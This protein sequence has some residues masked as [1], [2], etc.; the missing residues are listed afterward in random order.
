MRK[1][2]IFL[3]YTTIIEFLHLLTVIYWVSRKKI[4][5]YGT[6]DDAL[7]SSISSG[8]LTGFPDPHLIFIQ[9]LISYPIIWLESLLTNFSGYTIFLLFGTTIS[10]TLVLVNRIINKNYNL[11]FYLSW[12]FANIIFHSWFAINPTYTG[13]SLFTSGAAAAL[14]IILLKN[15]FNGNYPLVFSIA[16]LFTL[17]YMIRI[18]GVYIYFLI[19]IPF[20]FLYLK[21]LILIKRKIGIII[22]L[23]S[24]PLISNMGLS[25]KLYEN[26][27]WK[28]YTEMNNLRHKIQL[29]EPE[30]QMDQFLSEINWDEP[31][32]YMFKR[33]VL[34]DPDFMNSASMEKIIAQTNDYVGI[35]SVLKAEPNVSIKN[36]IDSLKPW[37]WILQ[38][39]IFIIFLNL[40]IRI[41]NLSL[42]TKYIFEVSILTSSIFVLLYTLASGF[43]LPEAITLN[44]LAA[45]SLV[46]VCL[47]P[48]KFYVNKK[49]FINLIVLLVSG[50][51]VFKQFERFVI[52]LNAR[53]DYYKTRQAFALQQKQS[54]NQLDSEVVVSSAASLKFHWIYPYNKYESFDDRN[55]T[56]ILGWHNLSPAWN[57]AASNLGLDPK[58]IYSSLVDNE[59]VWVDSENNI[60]PVL[61]FLEINQNANLQFNVLG[62]VGNQEY[63]FYK[64][65]SID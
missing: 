49:T 42:V 41:N 8:K 47:S 18:E 2:V 28:E 48:D 44:L 36:A 65:K 56:L 9:P 20:I 16:F 35:K 5:I 31:T 22:I 40:Y 27:A 62:D 12:L 1:L 64:F 3:F 26:D 46:L 7:I 53:E 17:S 13:A 61:K 4:A 54:F 29:R 10:F 59:A 52:E 57:T 45:Y 55:L 43:H 24:I 25:L 32:Q 51:M 38:T 19:I 37:T 39:L 63:R 60:E 30:R 58:N 14:T 33:L 34:V 50:V 23:V 21:N 11:I 6:N 15:K